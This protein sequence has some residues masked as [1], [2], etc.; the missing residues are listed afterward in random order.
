MTP[1]RPREPLGVRE[2]EGAIFFNRIEHRC[3]Y[4]ATGARIDESRQVRYAYDP[5]PE[6]WS[7]SE[8][9]QGLAVHEEIRDPVVYRA[10]YFE[11]WGHFL[12]ESTS[13]LW[14]E[15]QRPELRGLP[16][17]YAVAGGA[18]AIVGR[19][20]EFLEL[21]GVNAMPLFEPGRRVR[22]SK[23]YIPDASFVIGSYA[24]PSHLQAPH[25]VARALVGAPARDDQPVYFSRSDPALGG[26]AQRRMR[27][28]AELEGELARAGVRIVHMQ[29]LS[30]AEQ[31]ALM[32]TH[33]VFIGAWG[34]A[35]HNLFFCLDPAQVQ[36]FVLI[37][38]WPPRDFVLVDTIVGNDAH[39]LSVQEQAENYEETRETEVDVEA[40]LRYLKTC[41]VL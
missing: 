9:I 1:M 38:R 27:N 28:E 2:V 33:R 26:H 35:F 30:L 14:A 32:N 22:F 19:Y 34:S 11:H 4:D 20:A 7:S 37:P 12:L 29:T 8:R 5:T 39:Y 17:V 18:A 40:T 41:G 36:T 10:V 6:Y 24:H 15:F 13:R 25:R 16:S 3:L 31:V 21:A 23:C